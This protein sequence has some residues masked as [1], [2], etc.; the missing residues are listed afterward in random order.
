MRHK[1]PHNK[2]C[3]FSL[4]SE[5]KESDLDL[6]WAHYANAHCG[7]RIDFRINP[8]YQG[9]VY[10]IKYTNQAPTYNLDEISQHLMK[11]MTI[12]KEMLWIQARVSGD[13]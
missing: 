2:I 9:K 3:S 4:E 1:K 13:N 8:S 5:L 11:I 6:M 7:V 10:K 12:K